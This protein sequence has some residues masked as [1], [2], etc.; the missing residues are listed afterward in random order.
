MKLTAQLRAEIETLRARFDQMHTEFQTNAKYSIME[1]TRTERTDSF[2][3]SENKEICRLM[4]EELNPD[5]IR[6]ENILCETDIK[7]QG[8]LLCS[9][10]TIGTTFKLFLNELV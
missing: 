3:S 9:L 4:I 6:L 1:F 2:I 7:E 10:W 5:K 8:H